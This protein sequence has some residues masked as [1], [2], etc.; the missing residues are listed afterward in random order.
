MLIQCGYDCLAE[1]IGALPMLIIGI[2]IAWAGNGS[3]V[4]AEQCS[5][6]GPE[7]CPVGERSA[8]LGFITTWASRG[9]RP[10]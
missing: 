7:L 6:F 10:S 9:A 2:T 1:C 5:S 4:F 8:D 3:H